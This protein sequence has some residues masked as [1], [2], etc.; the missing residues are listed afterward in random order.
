MGLVDFDAGEI[1]EGQS[2]TTATSTMKDDVAKVSE[3]DAQEE[4]KQVIEGVAEG[5]K[6]MEQRPDAEEEDTKGENCAGSQ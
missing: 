6:T 5:T 4:S 3:E 1:L 2:T